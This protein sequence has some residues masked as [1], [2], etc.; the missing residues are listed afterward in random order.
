MLTC[1][2]IQFG[3]LF[4]EVYDGKTMHHYVDGKKELSHKLKYKPQGGGR[5]SIGMRLNQVYWFQGAIRKARFTARVLLPTEFQ[6]AN[7]P[8]TRP[9]FDIGDGAGANELS[10]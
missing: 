9:L 3:A 10:R 1:D 8:H 6:L 7:S 5:T 4:L 2:R